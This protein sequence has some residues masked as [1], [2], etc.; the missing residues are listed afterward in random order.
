MSANGE[1]IIDSREVSKSY[2]T[3]SGHVAA[4]RH[5]SLAVPA[6]AVVAN[7]SPSGS[8]K[9]TVLTLLSGPDRPD[10]GTA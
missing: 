8:V 2:R 10:A 6:G 9:T 1:L 5:V 7:I 3:G 4:L